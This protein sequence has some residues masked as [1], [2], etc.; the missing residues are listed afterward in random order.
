VRKGSA[1]VVLGLIDPDYALLPVQSR[2]QGRLGPRRLADTVDGLA[3]GR[4]TLR[5]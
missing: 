5:R 1:P 2:F 3:M 4:L